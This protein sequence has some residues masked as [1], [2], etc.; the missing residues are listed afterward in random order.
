MDQDTDGREV[1][2]PTTGKLTTPTYILFGGNS[3]HTVQN[4]NIK[5][6]RNS[7]QKFLKNFEIEIID[8]VGHLLHLDKP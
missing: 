8:G 7:C 5:Q 3:K 6:I 1:P 4:P 2:L